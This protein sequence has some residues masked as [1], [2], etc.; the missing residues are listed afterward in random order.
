MFNK[1]ASSK[2]SKPDEILKTLSIAPGSKVADIGSGGGYFTLRFAEAV[3]ENGQVFAV[4]TKREFLDNIK[5]AASKK[6]LNNIKTVQIAEGE[7]NLPGNSFDLI[8]FRNVYHHLEDRIEYMRKFKS[9]LKPDGK[10][11][12][13]E[14]KP[15]GSIFH[16]RRF[17]G[18]NVPQ[19]K[20]I[21]EMEAAGFK[22]LE[23]HDFLPEQS[24]TIFSYT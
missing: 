24:F 21:A 4:D 16:F 10:I 6:G 8:F 12:I 14:Y 11:A 2:K 20:I 3:G 7:V 13:V 18:H 1:K 22:K 9:K 17:F 19:G 15:G 23:E 5:H